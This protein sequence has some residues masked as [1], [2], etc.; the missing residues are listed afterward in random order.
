MD[1][2]F[3]FLGIVLGFVVGVIQ[4]YDTGYDKGCKDTEDIVTARHILDILDYLFEDEDVD[5]DSN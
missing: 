2:L 1:F 4:G 3:M 5:E